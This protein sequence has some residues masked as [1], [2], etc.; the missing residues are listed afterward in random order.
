MTKRLTVT[1]Y[2][3]AAKITRQA[4]L[5]RIAA[6]TIKATL[7]DGRYLIARSQLFKRRRRW[8]EKTR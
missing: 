6:G 3:A 7:V 5:K 1:E 4:V 8:E 2:A